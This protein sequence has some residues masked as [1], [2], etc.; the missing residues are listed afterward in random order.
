M[1]FGCWGGTVDNGSIVSPSRHVSAGGQGEVVGIASRPV[2]QGS[3]YTSHQPSDPIQTT[4]RYPPASSMP[5]NYS[6]SFCISDT[7]IVVYS[8]HASQIQ[9]SDA[10]KLK[11]FPKIENSGPTGCNRLSLTGCKRSLFSVRYHH[12]LVFMVNM[13]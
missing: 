3:D 12:Q 10:L 6:G 7:F 1:L 8:L 4:P 11:F 5:G 13:E 9:L 2:G